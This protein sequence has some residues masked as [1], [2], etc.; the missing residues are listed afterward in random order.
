MKYGIDAC[1]DSGYQGD[2]PPSLSTSDYRHLLN[3]CDGLLE[4]C[5]PEKVSLA[6]PSLRRTISP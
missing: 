5:E 4:W 2:D 3:L 1:K 6:L